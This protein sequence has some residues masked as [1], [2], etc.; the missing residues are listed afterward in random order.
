MIRIHHLNCGSLKP[1]FPD[2]QSIVYCLLVETSQGLV[3]VD[4]GFGT[5]DYNNPSRKMNFFLNWMG[6][7]R[8]LEETAIFQVQALGYKP[9]D[10]K[11]IIQTHLHIDH[12]WGLAD[13]PWA[14]V[15]VHATEYQAIQ[16]PKGFMEFAYIQYHWDHQPRWVRHKESMV[17]WFGLEAIPILETPEYDFLFIPLHGHTRGHCGVAIGKPGSWLLHCGDAASPFYRGADLHNRDKS[18]QKLNILPKSLANRI[19]GD[20][21]PRL[22]KILE[23]HGDEVKAISAHDIFSFWEYTSL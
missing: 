5:R 23:E 20:H 18:V 11:Y 9:K 21:M 14:E 19:L 17:D 6:V 8:N 10:V 7:P 3:L 2:V 22:R 15:H 12:A 16:N 13:F 1:P 4:T